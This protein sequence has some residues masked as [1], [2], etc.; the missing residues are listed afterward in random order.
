MQD[1]ADGAKVR[2][3]DELGDYALRCKVHEAHADE[4]GK[5]GSKSC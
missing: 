1:A 3:H 4:P 2:A 5:Q